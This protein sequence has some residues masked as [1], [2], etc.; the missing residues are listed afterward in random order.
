MNFLAIDTGGKYLSVAAFRD[1]QRYLRFQPDLALQHSIRLMDEIDLALKEASLRPNDCDFFAVV[2]GPGSF[3]GIRIGISTVK[4][5]CLACDK[6]ALALTSFD[7]LAYTAS[8]LQNAKPRLALVDAG[9]GCFY[10][11]AYDKA[12]NVVRAP[13][14]S[15]M[16]ETQRLIG[17]GFVPIAAEPLALQGAEVVSPC[18]GLLEAALR[19][20]EETRSP[21]LLSAMYLRK[22]SA[23]ENRK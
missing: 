19:K 4:G 21:S 14:F 10:T 13:A 22:S 6:P 15:N 2:V 16:E 7:A 20:A 11:C 12:G 1:G 8:C 5:L 23:E 18:S 3:T 17:E 9:H